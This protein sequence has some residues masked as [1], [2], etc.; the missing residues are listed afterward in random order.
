MIMSVR[1]SDNVDENDRSGHQLQEAK[2]IQ[3]KSSFPTSSRKQVGPFDIAIIY[4]G[5]CQ[6]RKKGMEKCLLLR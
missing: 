3:V 1:K 5:P 2:E 6:K 4:H